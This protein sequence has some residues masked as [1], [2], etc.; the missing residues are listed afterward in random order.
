MNKL[1]ADKMRGDF[2]QAVR[3][4][5][6]GPGEEREELRER[7]HKKYLTGMLFPRGAATRAAMQDEEELPDDQA[8]DAEE[9]EIESPTDLLFQKLP[10]SA[11]L[12][13]ALRHEEPSISVRAAAACYERAEPQVIAE[14]DQRSNGGGRIWKR[15]PLVPGGAPAWVDFEVRDGHQKKSVLGGK[16]T[17]HVFIRT[18]HGRPMATVSLLNASESE[19]D[20]PVQVEDVLFQVELECKPSLGVAEYPD[21]A[22]VS[23][24]PEARELAL[25]YRQLPT[26]A[27]G[28][29]C[30]ADWAAGPQGSVGA[31]FATFMPFVEVPPVTTEI[32]ELP[33][34]VKRALSMVRLQ[35]SSFDPTADF[36]VFVDQYELWVEKLKKVPIPQAF[37]HDRDRILS[38]ISATAERMRAG[39]SLLKSEPQARELFR[40]ANR[41]MLLSAARTAA[42][43]RGSDADY[44][45]VTL[46]DIEPDTFRWRPFQLAFF[47]L[48]LPGLWSAAHKDRS[49][50]DLI[51]FPTGGGK[52]EAYLAVA[53]FE[54]LRR[55]LVEASRGDGTAV[56]KRY[57]LRL[58]TIQQF[59]RAGSLICALESMRRRGELQGAPFTLGLWVGQ[60]SSPNDYAAAAADFRK[61][62][63]TIGKVEGV[64]IPLKQCPCCGMPILPAEKAEGDK[65]VGLRDAGGRIDVFCPRRECEYHHL[66]PIRF[67]DTDLYADP[68]TMLLGTIDKFAMLAWRDD[69]RAFFGTGTARLPPSL[70]IQDELHLISG[71][72]GTLAGVYEAAIDTAISRLGPP[73]KYICATAT[74]RRADDQIE[75]LYGRSSM[76]FPPAGLNAGDS[77]FSRTESSRP[78]RLYV[79]LMGQGH[80]PTFSNVIASSALLAAASDIR[81]AI[82]D[83]VDPWWTLV[84][85]H[86][87]KRELGKTLSLA[88]DDIPAR[89][90]ALGE[91]RYVGANGIREVSANLRDS[92]IPEALHQLNTELPGRQVLDFVACTNM[93]SV[94]V[95]VQRLGLMMINGQPK[96]V[97]EYIQASSRVGRDERRLPGTVFTLFS[98]S[99]PRD[100]SHYEFFSAFHRGF[101]RHVEPTSVTPFALPSQ[102]RALHG[103]FVA[104]VRMVSGIHANNAAARLLQHMDVVGELQK[105]LLAR[106]A[107]A[108]DGNLQ[109]TTDRLDEFVAFWRERA[110]TKGANLRFQSGGKQ[111]AAL[112]R[113]YRTPGDGWETLQ[114]LRHVDTPLRLVVPMIQAGREA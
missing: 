72:L 70:V 78:G 102:E 3:K 1:E 13:F 17:L 47:L 30:A 36:D 4:R 96:T 100:R 44:A 83:M 19:P 106:I 46:E 54:M 91:E 53:A 24:D 111:N 108:K 82:G 94:G 15:R 71:P 113:A 16:G 69:A 37:V 84:A 8:A 99:K 31:V 23:E 52:T 86:N 101:Y 56:I 25:Q 10:A 27:V 89:L 110:A 6:V 22:E 60:D 26:Y 11:G 104:L 62:L 20:K 28:H 39:V 90:K 76:L 49:V 59:E 58:L 95:D 112:M 18:S 45:D 33:S 67:V 7:P 55:R 81:Q 51:W 75:K 63:S 14:D 85:Y 65:G 21:P 34:D 98:P 35:Q 64:K 92:E 66:L 40:L 5:L 80:T 43:R 9:D 41:A 103:A 77:F 68:P 87:S 50:V 38:R 57:T 12:T 48:S 32:S 109:E 97:A 93:I 107:R 88:R 2:V 74:I 29:G 105:E 73:A 79:G 61:V 114:S 42:I